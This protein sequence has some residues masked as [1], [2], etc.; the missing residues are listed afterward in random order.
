MNAPSTPEFWTDLLNKLI[1]L[2]YFWA[3]LSFLFFICVLVFLI[4]KRKRHIQLLT[5]SSGHV[6]VCT[7]ALADLVRKSCNEL[8]PSSTPKVYIRQSNN[9]INVKIRVK[10]YVNQN[11]GELSTQM[12]SIVTKVLKEKLNI[13]NI[14]T[15]D[16]IVTGFVTPPSGPKLRTTPPPKEIQSQELL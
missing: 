13:E 14:G 9:R 6:S 11:I 3:A 4:K 16:V 12:K 2:P 15:I 7:C 10:F 8:N 1:F 5:D